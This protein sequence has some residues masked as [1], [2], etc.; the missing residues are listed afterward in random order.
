MPSFGDTYPPKFSENLVY[1]AVYDL[2]KL[3]MPEGG[4][5][6]PGDYF[7]IIFFTNDDMGFNE[8]PTLTY[9]KH[10]FDIFVNQTDTDLANIQPGS[11]IL[12]EFKDSAGTVIFSDVTP[13]HGDNSFTGYVWI[14]EDPLRTYESIQE[15][16]GYMTVVAK[17]QNSNIRVPISN[18]AQNGIIP[19]YLGS[20]YLGSDSLGSD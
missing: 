2:D 15:G 6:N 17:T 19:E 3:D 20:D 12:F 9:G 13:F 5:F 11:R 4:D 16:I 18:F 1:P 7:N 10:R 14:K 8:T